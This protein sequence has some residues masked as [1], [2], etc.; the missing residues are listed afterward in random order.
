M[1]QDTS[2]DWLMNWSKEMSKSS[3]TQVPLKRV[4]KE[5]TSLNTSGNSQSHQ[6]TQSTAAS[7]E[8]LEELKKLY[9]LVMVHNKT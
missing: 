4:F 2:S 6:K 7:K 1:F 3:V 8:K 5:E 9:K